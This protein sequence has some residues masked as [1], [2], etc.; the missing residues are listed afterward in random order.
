LTFK[1]FIVSTFLILLIWAQLVYSRGTNS[2]NNAGNQRHSE[3]SLKDHKYFFYFIDPTITN[4]GD[5]A[6]ITILTEAVR[7]D[8]ISRILYMRFEFNPAMKEIINTQKLLITLY[9]KVALREIDSATALLN[10]SAVEVFNNKDSKS[11]LYLSLGYRSVDFARKVKI[12]SDNLPKTNY[13]IR[14]YEYVKAIKSA[15]YSKRYAIIALIENRLPL[16]KKD[17]MD[18]NKY[19]IVQGLINQYIPENIEKYS[20][21]HFDDFYKVDSSKSIYEAIRSNPEI[22]KIPEYKDY[23][24]GYL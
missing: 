5:D 7:R 12:M 15:K 8:L 24:K 9:S 11:K 16:E 2:D 18:Y 20:A 10:E 3:K 23:F 21:I 6:E 19:D 14:L 13:S 1:K 4:S 17:R 22:E